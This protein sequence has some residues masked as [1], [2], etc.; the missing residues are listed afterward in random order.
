MKNHRWMPTLLVVLA[1]G[2]GDDDEIMNEN[3]A[4]PPEPAIGF[5][6]VE[7]A[8]VPAG[9]PAGETTRSIGVKIWYPAVTEGL[10]SEATYAVAGIVELDA[11][12]V[13][14]GPAPADGT[15]PVAVYSH[16]SGGDGLLAYPFGEQFAQNGWILVAPDHTG[17]TALD[18]VSDTLEPFSRVAL[19]RPQDVSAVLDWLESADGRALVGNGNTSQV[20]VTG[21]SF[22]G[23]TTLSLA[24]A[25]LDY[26]ALNASCG[27]PTSADC[28]FLSAPEVEAAFDA[29]AGDA[30]VVASAPQ[31]PALLSVYGSG[32]VAAI[33]TPTLLMSGRLDQTTTQS[34][35]A[36]PAWAV[37][38]QSGNIWI[39]IP[40]G[41]HYTFIT[42]C[43]D[44]PAQIRLLF[45]PDSDDDGCG[46]EFIPSAEAVPVIGDYLLA[47]ARWH[48]LGESGEAALFDQMIEGF[49]VTQP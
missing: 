20:F 18:G 22:G 17:N 10:E 7:L 44:L 1:A 42:I 25:D 37:L 3:N 45:Q 43:D 33:S 49:E 15:H 5:A 40:T 38:N 6:E 16:G 9:L 48:V 21:H 29:G 41:A 12:G 23:A 27:D 28:E 19:F 14:D 8:Y 46:P 47:F 32:E 26:D 13:L 2:C 30:R 24:G 31:A 36:D 39:D 34:E 35:S 4:L 11:D